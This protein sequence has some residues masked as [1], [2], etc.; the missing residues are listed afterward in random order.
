[1]LPNLNSHT[2]H[3]S[4]FHSLPIILRLHLHINLHTCRLAHYARSVKIF[5][6]GLLSTYDSRFR[7]S[8]SAYDADTLR[9][10][11]LRLFA[12]AS[13]FR[14]MMSA[15]IYHLR[16]SSGF[17]NFTSIDGMISPYHDY[18]CCDSHPRS[19]FRRAILPFKDVQQL[20]ILISNLTPCF[21]LLSLSILSFLHQRSYRLHCVSI[22]ASHI[23][24]L[25][26]PDLSGLIASFRLF[27]TPS[28]P[29]RTVAACF[30]FTLFSD[31][32]GA[33]RFRSTILRSIPDVI[34][35]DCFL[36]IYGLLSAFDLASVSLRASYI[37]S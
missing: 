3:L 5:A 29:L 14:R 22:F 16:R 15:C 17:Y 2:R 12:T 37:L 28:A 13:R 31:L 33:L 8:C 27:A 1:M 9:F 7:Y 4:T 26:T 10:R 6:A 20:A 21:R 35:A 25:D 30:V 19:R 36:C 23:R 34:S 24:L 32:I 18:R 11:C